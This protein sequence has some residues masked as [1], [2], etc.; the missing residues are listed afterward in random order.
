MRKKLGDEY[1]NLGPVTGWLVYVEILLHCMV[2]IV[3]THIVRAETDT[4]HPRASLCMLLYKQ[5]HIV[6]D[7]VSF[8]DDF[9]SHWDSKFL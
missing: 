8:Y 7:P 6:I 1:L 4:L 3:P 9:P 2:Q 5:C